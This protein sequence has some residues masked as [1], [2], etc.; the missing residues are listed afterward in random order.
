MGKT[1]SEGFTLIE[2]LVALS[3]VAVLITVGMPALRDFV[4]TNRMSSAVNDLVTDLHL[5][6]SE[7]IKRNLIAQICPSTNWDAENPECDNDASFADGWILLI[8]PDNQAIV[9]QVHGPLPDTFDLQLDFNPPIAFSSNGQ[10]W[11]VNLEGEMNLLLCDERGDDNT[12]A[13]IAGGRWINIRGTGRPRV[14]AQRA[15]I[16]SILGG[17]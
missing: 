17:C 1:H 7:A 4:A 5:A 14:Y 3:I 6:R 11:G 15:D 9:A 8:D 2:L 12:G 10:L 16:Q 13:G